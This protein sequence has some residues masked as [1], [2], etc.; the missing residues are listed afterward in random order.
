[1][2]DPPSPLLWRS[3][4]PDAPTLEQ[5]RLKSWNR[6]E[7]TVV[8]RLDAQ[9]FALTYELD[10]GEDGS[11]TIVNLELAGGAALTLYRSKSGVWSDHAGHHL[12]RL[13]HCSDVDIRVTPI[14]NSLALRRLKLEVGK[15]GDILVAWVNV[16]DLS[17][18][19]VRQRYTR[20]GEQTYRYKNLESGLISDLSVDEDLLVTVY[21]EAFER[22]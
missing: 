21:P 18:R 10:L 7:G 2:S 4:N 1:M 13:E 6:I 8:G 14:T 16:P 11:P 20:T 12:S 5:V 22:L 15:S 19:A 9:P 3:L 17:F